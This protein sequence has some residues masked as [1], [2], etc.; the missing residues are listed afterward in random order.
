MYT[1]VWDTKTQ[2]LNLFTIIKKC[3]TQSDITT[4][5]ELQ[6]TFACLFLLMLTVQHKK[7]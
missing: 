1:A 2:V 6:Y 3:K 7:N 4:L 5:Y